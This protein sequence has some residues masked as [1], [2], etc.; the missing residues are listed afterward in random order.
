MRADLPDIVRMLADDMLGAE[1]EEY[2]SPLPASY[3]RAFDAI[4]GDPMAG[5]SV[6]LTN[7]EVGNGNVQCGS[8]QVNNSLVMYRSPVAGGA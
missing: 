1:R 5:G 7:D 3:H 8:T 6:Y 2:A 4:D